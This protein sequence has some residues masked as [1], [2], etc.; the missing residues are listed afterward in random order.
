MLHIENM[1]ALCSD[2]V[3]VLFQT[4]NLI[5]SHLSILAEG[6]TLALLMSANWVAVVFVYQR[7]TKWCFCSHDNERLSS[8]REAVK[9][10]IGVAHRRSV[11]DRSKSEQVWQKCLFML[12]KSEWIS[13][14]SF[15]QLWDSGIDLPMCH[16]YICT[17]TGSVASESFSFFS[18]DDTLLLFILRFRLLKLR[19]EVNIC[20]E[21]LKKK[22]LNQ[23]QKSRINI[24]G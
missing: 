5:H 15:S 6:N 2:Y 18:A 11:S 24:L 19:F 3:S 22:S 10:V 21:I 13:L 17:T 4:A 9:E 14:M 20:S 8:V 1:H 16:C 12:G 7:G 23:F